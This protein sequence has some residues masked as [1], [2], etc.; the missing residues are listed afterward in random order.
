VPAAR[1]AIINPTKRRFFT[2]QSTQTRNNATIA[3]H[4][5]K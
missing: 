4:I 1:K 3:T 2:V 5:I